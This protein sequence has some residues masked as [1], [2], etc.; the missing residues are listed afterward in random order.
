MK[1]YEWQ[2]YIS[3]NLAFLILKIFPFI[4]R[5]YFTS[6]TQLSVRTGSVHLAFL[7]SVMIK[8]LCVRFLQSASCVNGRN[9]ALVHLSLTQIWLAEVLKPPG[10][11]IMR[12]SALL[13]SS[14]SPEAALTNGNTALLFFFHM[15][16]S[17]QSLAAMKTKNQLRPHHTLDQVSHS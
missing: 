3:K 16:K 11:F 17:I 14:I 8:S 2:K 15:K 6:L 1:P 7:I 4:Y 12:L 5:G 13:Q 10:C 9:H